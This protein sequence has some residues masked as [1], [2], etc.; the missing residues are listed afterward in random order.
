[1]MKDLQSV[2][3]EI[4]KH[5][6]LGEY[7]RASGLVSNAVGEEQFSCQFHG[8]DNKKSARF[9]KDT[10]TAYCWVCKE[11]WDLYS[12]VGRAQTMSFKECLEYLIKTYRVDISHLPEATQAKVDKHHERKV[13]KIASRDRMIGKLQ[14]A[15]SALRDEIDFEKYKKLVYSFMVLEHMVH[16]ESFEQTAQML[17]EK[18]LKVI[19]EAA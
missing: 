13:V 11:K 3:D 12:Y 5:I 10:D 6:T 18:T 19:K 17:K 16:D 8:A 7:L 15:I 2:K 1:M 4:K 9:Y 14:R